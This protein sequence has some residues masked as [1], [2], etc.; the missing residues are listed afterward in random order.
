MKNL[1][2]RKS[3]FFGTFSKIFKFHLWL[4]RLVLTECWLQYYRSIQNL[5]LMFFIFWTMIISPKLKKYLML[6][7][8]QKRLF[9]FWGSK[10][11]K[12]RLWNM[13]QAV[14]KNPAREDPNTHEIR[15][16]Y[17][18]FST[19]WILNNYGEIWRTKNKSFQIYSVCEP[20]KTN[21]I[22]SSCLIDFVKILYIF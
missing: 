4:N 21:D 12:R 3:E 10:G 18:L 14:R 5:F 6:Q 20:C 8:P 11:L 22:F 15:S 17:S 13:S 9:V 1:Y 16:G 19:K 2:L 7:I